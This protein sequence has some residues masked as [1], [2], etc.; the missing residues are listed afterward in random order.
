MVVGERLWLGAH[1]CLSHPAGAGIPGAFPGGGVL[2]GAGELGFPSCSSTLTSEGVLF[3]WE[4]P[5]EHHL[6]GSPSMAVTQ[7]ARVAPS[8]CI[9]PTSDGVPI[10]WQHSSFQGKP[11]ATAAPIP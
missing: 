6:S 10:L 5:W 3:P 11:H 2:P 9:I 4:H 1:R 8:L 7:P